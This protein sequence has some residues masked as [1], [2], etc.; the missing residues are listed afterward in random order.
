MDNNNISEKVSRFSFAI[1][2]NLHLIRQSVNELKY[3]SNN[4]FKGILLSTAG[5]SP[6][7]FLNLID[8]HGRNAVILLYELF[9][10][11]ISLFRFIELL[12]TNFKYIEFKNKNV[13]RE[14][15]LDFVTNAENRINNLKDIYLESLKKN[16]DKISAH[17]D[18]INLS[19]DG[20]IA[21]YVFG[22]GK[23]GKLL[24]ELEQ[25]FAPLYF[26]LNNEE[27]ELS[28][29]SLVEE[30]IKNLEKDFSEDETFNEQ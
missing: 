3:V 4:L 10:G 2:R 16:R 18:M 12:K 15:I 26:S 7:Y 29:K 5:I 19:N 23:M 30:F 25:V 8:I 22:I 21:D 14:T 28:D 13:N 17:Q 24:E 20:K 27:Y 1:N 6:Y 9:E 11:K